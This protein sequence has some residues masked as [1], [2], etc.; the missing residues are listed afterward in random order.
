MI[1]VTYTNIQSKIK[2]NGLLSEPCTIMQGV[3]HGYPLWMLLHIISAKVLSIFI[4][5]DTRIKGAMK[6]KNLYHQETLI[7]SP[8]YNR[9]YNYMK[10][11]LAQK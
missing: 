6:K 10:K 3:H 11:L 4:D 9:F 1:R 7:N 5:A 2:T 8:D